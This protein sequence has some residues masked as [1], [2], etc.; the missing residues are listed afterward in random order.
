L[1]VRPKDEV[2]FEIVLGARRY[3]AAQMAEVAAVPVR[4]KYMTAA[5]V[6]EA[7]LIELSR[8]GKRFLCLHAARHV[9]YI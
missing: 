7:Q 1:L 3:R 9:S 4:I 2:N 6:L 8:V 5:E